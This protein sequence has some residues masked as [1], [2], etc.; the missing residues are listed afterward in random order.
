MSELHQND[1]GYWVARL[2][3]GREKS[4][5]TK[6]RKMAEAIRN[7]W[8]TAGALSVGAVL[9][10]YVLDCQARRVRGT[11][12]YALKP[13][14]GFFA[15]LDPAD[16]TPELV[17]DYCG[18][19]AHVSPSTQRRELA[20]L[21]AALN[22][23]R[24]QGFVQAVPH[25]PLPT[26]NKRVRARQTFLDEEEEAVFYAYALGAS[27]GKPRLDRV[28]LFVC[29]I[30]DTAARKEAVLGL[31][32]DRVDLRGGTIDFRDPALPTTKKR[33]TV[34]PISFRLRPLLER[35]AR[36]RTTKYVL[37]FRDIRREY[38]AFVRDTPFPHITPHDLR[39]TWATL[40]ARAGVPLWEIAG[41][42]GDTVE[43]VTQHYAVHCPN[44]L[45]GA[46]D[47]RWQR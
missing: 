28:T 34:V 23:G 18:L 26:E 42:L 20:G 46:V 5:R 19:R 38:E 33:R 7:Q 21:V 45:R 11:H 6:S 30:M 47:V 29:L 39:R 27:V 16:I 17:R 8:Q 12:E 44:H 25:I 13:V 10:K 40:A 31:T 35:A 37:G 36:E 1:H 9:D 3:D 41:V 22:W 2:P 24:Q 4:T 43:V 15:R 14:R 32:W